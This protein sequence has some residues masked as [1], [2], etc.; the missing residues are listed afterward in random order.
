M[1]MQSARS[2]RRSEV[3]MGAGGRAVVGML[4]G[5]W[6]VGKRF[7]RGGGRDE[8]LDKSTLLKHPP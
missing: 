1:P 2:R 8:D 7:G 3:L 6:V 5:D 4:N